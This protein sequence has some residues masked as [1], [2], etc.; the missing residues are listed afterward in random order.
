MALVPRGAVVAGALAV[1]LQAGCSGRAT[2]PT[3]TDV[4]LSVAASPVA[5]SPSLPVVADARV[6]NAGTTRVWHCEGCGCGNGIGLTVLGPD[7]VEVWLR[8]PN[9]ALPL[10]PDAVMPLDPGRDLGARLVFTG[11][12]YAN[13]HPTF[14]SPTYPA[15]PGTYTVIARFTYAISVPGEW[16]PLERRTTFAWAP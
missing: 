2:R 9:A 14:P 5:G 10:C 8:D 3:V 7:G 16:V 15:P 11:T 6:S 4:D 1:L 13:G 12:L